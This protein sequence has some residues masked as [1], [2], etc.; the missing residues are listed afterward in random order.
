MGDSGEEGGEAA[1]TQRARAFA[2]AWLSTVT[3][4][5]VAQ[6]SPPK[7]ADTP[8]PTVLVLNLAHVP[9]QAT[10]SALEG[11]NEEGIKAHPGVR[12]TFAVVRVLSPGWS[13]VAADA[14]AAA[15]GGRKEAGR[16][17]TAAPSEPKQKLCVMDGAALR[18]H[19]YDLA[20]RK[21][22][23][24]RCARSAAYATVMPGMVLS[25]K[26]WGNKFKQTFAGRAEDVPPFAFAV[27][28]LG[29]KSMQ[30]SASSSGLMLEVKSMGLAEGVSPAS[31][32]LLR[33]DL[34]PAT[35]AGSTALRERMLGDAPPAAED[36]PREADL[37][38][39]LIRG[40]VSSGVQVLCVSPRPQNGVFAMGPDGKI[41]L[42]VATPLGDVAAGA[43]SVR[44]DAEAHGGAGGGEDWMAKLLNVAA[45]FGAVELFL[46]LDAYRAKDVPP[47]DLVL[48]GFARVDAAALVRQVAGC[49]PAPYRHEDWSEPAFPA[50]S[51]KH[52]AIFGGC[53]PEV[54]LA[55]DTRRMTKRAGAAVEEY[56]RDP[57]AAVLHP[58]GRWQRA[59][60]VNVFF[61][62]RPVLAFMVPTLESMGVERARRALVPASVVVE[63]DGASFEEEEPEEPQA[64]AAPAAAAAAAAP[65][66]KKAARVAAE[67]P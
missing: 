27:V 8:G 25:L 1:V 43:V 51:A 24:L 33:A 18:M 5:E 37:D 54:D 12:A 26:I 2:E 28:Q 10:L 13:S 15:G 38:Q 59:N 3:A 36:P 49:P 55:V 57:S 22:S 4:L 31:T 40:N 39:G 60:L 45:L 56:P 42:H 19:S 52:V 61:Q 17:R 34:F 11:M 14:D 35:A 20:N 50:S 58:Q 21:G 62:K 7:T 66:P 32:A 44:C 65:R 30:S 46:L 64:A 53:V 67:K 29:M 16:K 9:V 23:Y 41:R 63:L 47:A 48:E 6:G